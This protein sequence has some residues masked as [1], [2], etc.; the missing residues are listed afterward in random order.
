MKLRG[1]AG[2]RRAAP[3]AGVAACAVERLPPGQELRLPASEPKAVDRLAARAA[4]ARRAPS[5][6][7]TA[8]AGD[9]LPVLQRSH[10]GHQDADSAKRR[11][12]AEQIG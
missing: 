12:A 5:G 7:A 1:R 8:T 9:A 10:G 4:Q 3:V 11:T 6:A 2:S